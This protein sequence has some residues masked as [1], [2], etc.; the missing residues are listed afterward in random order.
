M[1]IAGNWIELEIILLRE[2]TETQKDNA[3]WFLLFVDV[4]F[5]P[6]DICMLFGTGVE[7]RKL[8]RNC[9]VRFQGK[10]GKTLWYKGLERENGTS[11]IKWGEGVGEEGRRRDAEKDI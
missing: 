8:L 9:G 1:T 3:A 10:A 11:C 6:S 5:E 4:S 7:V 2:V